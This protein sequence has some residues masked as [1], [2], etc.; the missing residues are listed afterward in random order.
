MGN[1][2]MSTLEAAARIVEIQETLVD[3]FLGSEKRRELMS[4][5]TE[6][7]DEEFLGCPYE[8]IAKDAWMHKTLYRWS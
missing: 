2:N 7:W 5:Q 3:A 6:L 1:Q 4:E 8:Q